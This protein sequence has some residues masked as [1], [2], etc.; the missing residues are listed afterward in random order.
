MKKAL[1]VGILS[2]AGWAAAHAYTSAQS[3]AGWPMQYWNYASP[4]V[5]IQQTGQAAAK[6]SPE[7]GD[8]A[9]GIKAIEVGA[10]IGAAALDDY[11]Q[12]Q[13]IPNVGGFGVTQALLTRVNNPGNQQWLRDRLGISQGLSKCATQCVIYP[14]A[15]ADRLSIWGCLAETGGDGLDCGANGWNGQWMGVY[16][17]SHAS[18]D[19]TMVSCMTAKNWSGNRN[20][21][22]WVVASDRNPLSGAS[23]GGQVYR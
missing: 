9:D 11:L 2:I 7:C 6:Q 5:E 19:S 22:F 1:T 16:N 23:L 4:R 13:G 18:T 21:W 10:K 17:L 3:T 20:R 8:A 12:T 15:E 14:K